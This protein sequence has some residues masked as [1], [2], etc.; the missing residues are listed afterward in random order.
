MD[1]GTLP[2]LAAIKLR[3]LESL[4]VLGASRQL[5]IIA[6]ALVALAEEYDG[7]PEGLIESVRSLTQYL[8]ATRGQS[9]QAIGNALGLMTQGLNAQSDLPLAAL[10]EWITSR[11]RE[12]DT[13]AGEWIRVLTEHG[14]VQ[15]NGARRV[16]AY[17]YS[18]SVAAILRAASH[19]STEPITAV[20]PEARTLDGGRKYVLDLADTPLR[21]EVVPDSAIAS[22]ISGCDLVLVGA[23][24][25]TTEGGCYNTVG[26]F[27]TALAAAHHHVPFYVASTLIKIDMQT[28]PG[29]R[30][31]IPVLDMSARLLEGWA[32]EDSSRVKARCPDLDYTPPEPIAAFITEQGILA[33][34]ELGACASRLLDPK[35][36]V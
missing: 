1:A 20:L 30:R 3:E 21:F 5:G 14:V 6:D 18:S 22:V 26:T 12:Y 27:L 25:L 31:H 24:T 2:P 9:S 10:R 17:D 28:L 29:E 11:V 34:C 33:P 32:P 16:L 8:T 36:S 35:G 7:T 23:E 19:A 4:Q 15:V 13:Q